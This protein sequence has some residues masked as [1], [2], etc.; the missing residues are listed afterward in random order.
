MPAYGLTLNGFRR[1]RLED[2][3]EDLRG[4]MRAAF[5]EDL[6]LEPR[7]AFSKLIDPFA[8]QIDLAWQAAEGVY[9]ANDAQAAVGKS[10][11]N[12][13]YPYI[14]GRLA[15]TPSTVTVT[16]TAE[17]GTTYP[18]GTSFRASELGVDLIS[19]EAVTVGGSGTANIPL[20]TL[21]TGPVQVGAGKID[22]LVTFIPGHTGVTNASAATPGTEVEDDA[23]YRQRFEATRRALG[24]RL[25]DSIEASLLANPLIQYASAVNNRGNRESD[26][27]TNPTTGAL[28]QPGELAVQ[29]Y[30]E[31]TDPDELAAIAEILYREEPGGS[32]YAGDVEKLVIAANG[33]E[34]SVKWSW[35]EAVELYVHLI[36]LVGPD[37]PTN[38][39]DQIA[40]LVVERGNLLEVSQDV[41]G[42]RLEAVGDEVRGVNNVAAFFSTTPT[43]IPSASDYPI[44]ANQIARF[45]LSRVTQSVV[46]S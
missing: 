13:F 19:T 33:R 18:Q 1:K 44:T 6:D 21:D 9:K 26:I 45:D 5:G 17:D 38:A 24:H 3:R 23:T 28:L 34:H 42:F 2:I 31:L 25:E 22:T 39:G 16:V 40:E 10:L 7:S 46:T 29:I 32:P 41:V 37:A 36:I 11:E 12:L 4:G 27:W 20:I 43:P 8:G 15:A 14:G 35:V 30:P